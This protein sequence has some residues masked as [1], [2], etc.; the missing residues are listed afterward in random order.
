MFRQGIEK[1]DKN[2]NRIKTRAVDRQAQGAKTLQK[3]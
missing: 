2:K 1:G 3:L